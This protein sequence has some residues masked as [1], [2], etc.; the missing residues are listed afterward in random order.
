MIHI[1]ATHLGVIV[2]YQSELDNH[3]DTCVVGDNALITHDFDRP[4][5]VSGYDKSVSRM[6]ACTVTA[7][8][9]YDDSLTGD[10]TLL[11]FH[12]AI[13]IPGLKHNL[14]FPM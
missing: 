1:N 14:L 10:V 4:V 12:Q 8:L 6:E 3:A 9:S 11:V 5:S 7:V 2:D 13:H